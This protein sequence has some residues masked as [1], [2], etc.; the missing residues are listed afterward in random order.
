MIPG[1]SSPAALVTLL[2]VNAVPLSYVL[3]FEWNL[4]SLAMLYWVE[5]GVIGLYAMLKMARATFAG[6]LG[7]TKSYKI[8]F[9]SAHYSTYWVF[10]GA[11]LGG[12]V[13]GGSGQSLH[14][15]FLFAI[16]V[17]LFA[18]SHGLSFGYNYMG[19][20]ENAKISSAV[21]MAVPYARTLPTNVVLV[22]LAVVLLRV[23]EGQTGVIVFI[24]VKVC[25]DAVMHRVEHTRIDKAL[26]L[27][28]PR[29]KED[30]ADREL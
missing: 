5:G 1:K 30:A 8:L 14:L 10:H 15:D 26:F 12:V 9:F 25:L 13:F 3:L 18:M 7:G 4:Y 29:A 28:P 19:R 16:M 17:A 2:I 21:Q 22:I 23:G 27:A 6:A 24:A 11:V 20:R